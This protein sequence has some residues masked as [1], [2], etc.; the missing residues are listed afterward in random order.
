LGTWGGFPLLPLAISHPDLPC[1]GIDARRK[2][3]LAVQSI[4]EQLWLNNVSTIRSRA[5]QMTTKYDYVT[6][7][8]VWY[9][10]R[11]LP[12]AHR[13]TRHGG[14][15]IL[16]KLFTPEEEDDLFTLAHGLQ[17]QTHLI[18]PYKLPDDD[19]QRVI[20]IFSK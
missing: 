15:I 14:Y 4:A 1:T 11:I 19:T 9:A 2:K 10:D 13:I 20:Y 5:E 17:L 16:Y 12:R 6:A 3:T 8:A 7:R 18:N